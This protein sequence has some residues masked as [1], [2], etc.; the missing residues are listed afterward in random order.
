MNGGGGGGGVS[1]ESVNKAATSLAP[2]LPGVILA[3]VVL[4]AVAV[5]EKRPRDGGLSGHCFKY[6]RLEEL[7]PN[8][9]KVFCG[10]SKGGYKLFFVLPL[11]KFSTGALVYRSREG[12][13]GPV[14]VGARKRQ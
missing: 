9:A 1:C 4:P 11:D 2:F 6:G 13:P 12:V 5:N 8:L 14:R 7:I 3:G 10:D